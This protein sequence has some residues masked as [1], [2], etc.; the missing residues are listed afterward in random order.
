LKLLKTCG[1][2]VI[3]ISRDIAELSKGKEIFRSLKREI[4]KLKG[5]EKTHGSKNKKKIVVISTVMTWA[6][7]NKK[8]SEL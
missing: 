3:D 6:G 5:M 4:V 1:I 8:A 2:I 7:V